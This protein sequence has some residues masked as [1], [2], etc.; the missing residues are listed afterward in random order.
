MK[1]Y[2][3]IKWK[4]INTLNKKYLCIHPNHAKE[5]GSAVLNVF[6]L[7][8]CKLILNLGFSCKIKINISNI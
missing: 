2:N 5:T 8:A 4:L 1:F 6:K 7:I 3:L